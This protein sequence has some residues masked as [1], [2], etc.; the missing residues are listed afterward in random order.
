MLYVIIVSIKTNQR[1]K[2]MKNSAKQYISKHKMIDIPN[3]DIFKN[4]KLRRQAYIEDLSALIENLHEP[5]TLS[6]NGSWGCG[7]TTFVKMWQAYLQKEKGIKSIYFSAWE[8]DFSKE[9]LIAILGEIRRYINENSNETKK[10]TFETKFSEIKDCSAKILKRA[11]PAFL[12][13]MTAGA[14][15]FDE[16]FE[17]AIGTLIESSTK[18]LIEQHSANKELMVKFKE[19]LK[20]L[21]EIIDDSKPFVIFVDEL[22]RCRPLYAIE[23]LERIKHIFGVEKLIF[24]LSIDKN[25]LAES[26]KS[27]YGAIDTDNYLRRFV[28][29]E[30]ELTNIDI[31]SFCEYLYNEFLLD[32]VLQDSGLRGKDDYKLFLIKF[33]ACSLDLSLREIEQIF[34]KMKL[35]FATTQMI[36]N[37]FVEVIAFLLIVKM[38]LPKEYNLL[39]K[40]QADTQKLIAKLT[41]KNDLFASIYVDRWEDFEYIE[42]VIIKGIVM[43]TGKSDDEMEDILIDLCENDE[44]D[45]EMQT[46]EEKAKGYY[47]EL[48]NNFL[49]YSNPNY[50]DLRDCFLNKLINLAIKKVEFVDRLNLN[51]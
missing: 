37:I 14:L 7:K 18:E 34:T 13:G 24:V 15:N 42:Q 41:N 45:L 49:E 39:I 43:A 31:F 29:L 44:M 47:A 20:Q 3:D 6:I 28:D 23:L 50:A 8:D 10:Q 19:S 46:K 51:I 5:L 16:G 26:I 30:F 36:D 17:R 48:L 32:E 11:L 22:D 21:I 35:I 40:G 27:Q 25:Q 33:L 2:T 12:S 1:A 4:D 9:P 38:K